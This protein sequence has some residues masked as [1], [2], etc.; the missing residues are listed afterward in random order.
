MKR[1]SLFLIVLGMT[2]LL[3]RYTTLSNAA[4]IDYMSHFEQLEYID[5]ADL[6]LDGGSMDF[7]FSMDSESTPDWIRGSTTYNTYEY[8]NIDADVTV[9]KSDGAVFFEGVIEGEV[10]IANGLNDTTIDDI[11]WV[12][13]IMVDGIQAQISTLLFFKWDFINDP[14][15]F[16]FQNDDF[17]YR[18]GYIW[19]QIGEDV[20]PVWYSSHNGVA[21]GNP[22]PEPTTLLLLG[23]GLVGLAAV[24]RKRFKK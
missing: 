14:T 24:G 8:H 2:V 17:Y 16:H 15:P 7:M 1:S 13:P 18:E 10:H 23:S 19:D 11:Q 21:S 9:K 12:G 3:L 4:R 20:F 5:G 22:V 6:G